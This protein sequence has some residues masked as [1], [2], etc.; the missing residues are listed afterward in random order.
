MNAKITQ[1]VASSPD[2]FVAKAVP[3]LDTIPVVAATVA[4]VIVAEIGV[5]MKQFPT[6][7]HLSPSPEDR[8]SLISPMGKIGR[9]PGNPDG[10]NQRGARPQV[11][12]PIG[13][14][15]IK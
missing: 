3:P 1:E 14:V 15:P 4:Q 8:P 7:K 10:A 11:G 13:R 12:I 9:D 2:P 5:E 6:A